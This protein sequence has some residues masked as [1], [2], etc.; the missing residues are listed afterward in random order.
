M[1]KET[2]VIKEFPVKG[3]VLVNQENLAMM[4]SLENLDL[5]V[6]VERPANQALK[7]KE[8]QKDLLDHRVS[9]GQEVGLGFLEQWV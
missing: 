2:R 1:R 4:D 5:L 8:G 9:R 6:L 7:D 3:V